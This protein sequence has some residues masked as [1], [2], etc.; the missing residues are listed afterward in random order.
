MRSLRC[1]L[2]LCVTVSWLMP[3]WALADVYSQLPPSGMSVLDLLRSKRAT[4]G[5]RLL[6]VNGTRMLFRLSKSKDDV[7]QIL[8]RLEARVNE[9]YADTA[10]YPQAPEDGMP[11][12]FARPFRTG[13]EGWGV[14]GRLAGPGRVDGEDGIFASLAAGRGLGPAAEGGFIVLALQHGGTGRGSDVW[15][16]RF[17][18]GFDPWKLM[19]RASGD[20]EGGDLPRIHRYPGSR[21]VM[22]ISELSEFGNHHSVAYQGDGSVRD[23]TSYYKRVMQSAGYRLDSER[24]DR[25]ASMTRFSGSEADVTVFSYSAASR[26][27]E[28]IDLIQY[29]P[30]E[31]QR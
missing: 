7:P 5:D 12:P 15:T 23:R 26:S 28:V 29:Q 14:V 16:A 2:L 13:G 31:Y 19:P 11:S 9:E 27:N 17:D 6:L 30:K 8:D 21:R 25:N 10:M 1:A 18:P 24:E 4:G 20:V 22:S 3:S